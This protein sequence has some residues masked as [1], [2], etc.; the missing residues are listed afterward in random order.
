MLPEII[1]FLKDKKILILGFGREGRSSFRYIRKYL[2]EKEITVADGSEQE[3]PDSF[4]KGIFGGGNLSNLSD[5]DVVLKSPGI[6]FK[7]RALQKA[8]RYRL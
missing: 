3:L 7:V 1:E 6:S 5:F 2:P 4:T 8:R